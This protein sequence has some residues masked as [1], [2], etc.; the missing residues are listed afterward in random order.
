M[1][2]YKVLIFQVLLSWSKP[3][4]TINDQMISAEAS[5]LIARVNVFVADGVR[6][7]PGH[8]F[9]HSNGVLPQLLNHRFDKGHERRVKG[10]KMSPSIPS[11]TK[12]NLLR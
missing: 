11:Y 9:E 3:N 10:N 8:C 6:I 4:C 1:L 5:I 12:R 2:D 7:S